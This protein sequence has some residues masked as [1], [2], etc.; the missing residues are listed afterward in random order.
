VLPDTCAGCDKSAGGVPVDVGYTIVISSVHEL[1]VGGEVLVT[2][3]FLAFEIHIKELHV[4]AL[5]R[6][7]GG[8]DDEA[9]LR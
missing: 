9:A 5:L 3:W 4:E 7:H 6:V 2:L 8:N 1:Q